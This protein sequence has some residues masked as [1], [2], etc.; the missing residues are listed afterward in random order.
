MNYS[1]EKCL[2]E[3]LCQYY[4]S[5]YEMKIVCGLSENT[6]IPICAIAASFSA[7]FDESI[8]MIRGNDTL[9]R[10]VHVICLCVGGR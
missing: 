5:C 9:L 6:A 8:T 3:C 10:Y 4:G 7:Y 1:K 2:E